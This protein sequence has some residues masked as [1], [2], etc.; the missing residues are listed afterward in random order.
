L[1]GASGGDNWRIDLPPGAYSPVFEFHGD[2][3]LPAA[4]PAPELAQQEGD[5][6]VAPTP[7][8]TRPKR[9]PGRL[10]V[11]WTAAILLTMAVAALFQATPDPPMDHFWGPFLSPKRQ[12]LVI[13]PGRD[14]LFAPPSKLAELAEAA[15]SGPDTVNLKMQ[16]D[17]FRVVPNAQ[18][19]VQ[20]FRAAVAMASFIGQR[21]HA[22]RFR[23]VS[24]RTVD[25]VRHSSVILIAACA[26]PWATEMSR[27]L[28]YYFRS[29]G[30]GHTE[31][32]WIEDRNTPGNPKWIV[33]KLWP[34]GPQDTDYAIVTRTIAPSSGQVVIALAGV[35][36][37][38]TQAAAESLAS[39]EFWQEFAAAAPEGWEKKNLQ[40]VLETRVIREIPHPPKILAIHTWQADNFVG[41]APSSGLSAL[42]STAL[43]HCA[44]P[45]PDPAS[46]LLL[47]GPRRCIAMAHAWPVRRLLPARG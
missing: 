41:S 21:G 13:L 9:F 15:G 19:S 32:C 44:A 12:V 29:E 38:G 23:L 3:A 39:P 18:M 26:N 17:E 37:F 31:V 10:M 46:L 4:A 43:H 36:G 35:N 2:T 34:Y 40:I 42:N 20:N 16:R 25:E 8:E 5:S 27:N 28:R 14:R 11:L 33:Q 30:Q 1:A 22:A 7:L 47:P 45:D 6:A 24:E